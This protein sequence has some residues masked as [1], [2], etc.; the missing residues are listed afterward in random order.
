MKAIVFE[1]TGG[2]EVLQYREVSLPAPIAGSV[3]LR[4]TAIGLNFIDTYHRSGLYKV[5]L[6]SGMGLEAAGVI[7]ALGPGVKGFKVGDRVA[8]GVGAALGA[9][10]QERNYP[11]NRLVKLPKAIKDETAAGMM[12]KGMTARY[13]LRATYNV[14]R[15][16]TIMVHAAAGGVGVILSQWAKALGAKVIGTVGSSEKVE[17]AKSNGCVHVIDSSKENIV[18]RVREIT[19]GKGVPVVYDGVG[20]ATLMASLD[21]LKPRGMLV[22]FGNASGPI[23]A[24]DLGLLAARGSLYVTRPTLMSY[25]STDDDFRETVD[26]LMEIV[27]SGK[28]QIPVNQHYALADARKAHEDLEARRTVGTTVLIP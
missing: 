7:E 9:Y 23:K 20:Q 19:D 3:R 12:L 17:I 8:Y 26:D 4:H 28:V 11:A 21:C 16:E 27:K 24:L 1:K 25:T 5:P 2:P 18:A 6:P 22:S 13:L 14:K 10:S 15:G